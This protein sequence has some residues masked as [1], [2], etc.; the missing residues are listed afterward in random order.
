MIVTSL[1][2]QAGGTGRVE[3]AKSG[4][5]IVDVSAIPGTHAPPASAAA[6]AGTGLLP[7]DYAT[8]LAQADGVAA[9]H[10]IL[11]SCVELPERNATY[12]VDRYAP[13]FVTVGDDGGGSAL[14]MRAGPG[15]SPVFRVGHG[16]MTPPDMVR[17]A[18]SL[19][20]WIG[21]GCPVDGDR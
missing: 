13:G 7:E 10:F 17:L 5:Q 9:D 15:R 2:R 3:I 8:L 1:G 4:Q 12:E 20:E 6:V 16:T 18:D 14:V 11:Y 21:A 19:A